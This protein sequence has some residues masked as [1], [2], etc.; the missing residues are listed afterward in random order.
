MRNATT[1]TA[2]AAHEVDYVRVLRA[3]ARKGV[4]VTIDGEGTVSAVIPGNAGACGQNVPVTLW[5]FLV[6]RRFV[7]LRDQ[8]QWQLSLRGRTE[9]KKK[10]CTPSGTPASRASSSRAD[11]SQPPQSRPQFNPEESPLAWLR[12]RRDKD[13]EPLISEPQFMAGERLRSDFHLAHLEPRVTA[14]WS[15]LGTGA[16][17]KRAAPGAG[18]ELQ[19]HVVAAQTRIHHALRA[20]G[21][22]LSGILIDVC[23]HLKGLSDSER[24]RSWPQ[25]SAKVILQIA[26]QALARH[27]GLER[28][29]AATP[30]RQSIRHWGSNDYR[31]GIDVWADDE[32]SAG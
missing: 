32:R 10:L 11:R 14:G 23:C 4:R 24:A 5:A 31:P 16:G 28:P 30:G 22:E 3:M 17:T 19:D 12:S 26:L 21:P 18:I 29:V 13:G 9:L 27:Y 6:E 7:A 1:G 8:D 20:V 2:Q 25:R 15:G